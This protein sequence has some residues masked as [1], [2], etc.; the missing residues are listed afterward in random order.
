VAAT[1]ALPLIPVD[2]EIGLQSAVLVPDGRIGIVI[3]FYR[4]ETGTTLVLLGVDESSEFALSELTLA[5]H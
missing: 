5:A 1:I 4:G 3:G 2:C